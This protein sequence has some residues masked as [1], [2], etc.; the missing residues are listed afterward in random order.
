MIPASMNLRAALQ[1]C[2][3]IAVYWSPELTGQ[4]ANDPLPV[5]ADVAKFVGV[6]NGT[7]SQ[8]TR[9]ATP[10]TF[11]YPMILEIKAMQDREITALIDWPDSRS[12]HTRTSGAGIVTPDCVSWV[13]M[14]YMQ[15]TDADLFGRYMARIAKDGTLEGK[16]FDPE[17]L[18][19]FGSLHL[20]RVDLRALEAFNNAN[21]EAIDRL[22]S[23]SE[24]IESLPLR[25]RRLSYLT[26]AWLT[27]R[28]AFDFKAPDDGVTVYRTYA[29]RLA[30]ALERRESLFAQEHI[31]E[32][33][34]WLQRGTN[35]TIKAC[36]VSLP[37]E[38]SNTNKTYPARIEVFGRGPG[39][40]SLENVV[41]SSETPF[42]T[43]R[44]ITETGWGPEALNVLLSE[45]KALFSVDDQRIVV[46]F[47]REV[48]T[49]PKPVYADNGPAGAC[50]SLTKVSIPNTT[51][52][53][54]A[55]SNGVCMVTATVTH[56]PAR[57]AVKVLIA[58]P[59]AGWNG[60]FRG[61]GGGGFRAGN[62]F[63]MRRAATLGYAAGTTDIRP[64]AGGGSF[65]LDA[66]GRL[67]WQAVVNFAYLGV[68]DMTVVGK[69]LTEAF[70]GKPPR[71]SYFVGTSTGGRQG[72]MEAQRYPADYDGIVS[73]AP[74]LNIPQLTASYMWPQL[75]MLDA[76]N[77][78]SAAKLN[79]ATT[80][81]IAAC[82]EQDGLKD[83]V[84]DEPSRCTYDPKTLVGTKVD[85]GT[86]TES[87]AAVIRKIWEG[88][89][90]RAGN[91][92]WHGLARGA[93]LL[94]LAGTDGTPLTGRP[95]GLTRDWFRY[96]LL[97]DPQWDWTTITAA[98]FERRWK[99]GIE[100][101]GAVIGSDDPDLT[102]FR[103]R[104][105]KILA[106]HG[107]ADQFI[108]AEIT[109][110]YYKRVQQRIGGA[111][112]TAEF[113]RLF[114]V[115]GVDHGFRGP[116][117]SPTGEID[118][119]IG[120]VEEGKAPDMLIGERRES[121][122]KLLGT[123]PLFAYPRAAKYKGRGSPDN[124]A[125]FTSSVIGQ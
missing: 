21:R 90:D 9:S 72:L 80:A 82:D 110:D 67:N 45:I 87:D 57:D 102:R 13:E 24:Q 61:E 103:D 18:Q 89:R 116:G 69:A 95:N 105:G 2:A 123:R 100:Q 37:S 23:A 92:L 7:F 83:G 22:L 32:I 28:L 59:M 97:Q 125:S 63:R 101:Y 62:T 112:K 5:H 15:R 33:P 86:F 88:P 54:A 104:G 107:L 31:A 84:I 122:G 8:K 108:P 117:P 58:L 76:K 79:A 26:T 20:K 74:A 3:G 71:Y 41:E 65:A 44:P 81:A 14:S 53:S 94:T 99:Q 40:V 85:D 47:G 93:S 17:D 4:T 121:N 109:I 34:I 56:P 42:I 111:E 6:W 50:E 96:F 30:A 70:Y 115:P 77:F 43:L 16:Y 11:S 60:R 124:A 49:L 27:N 19:E 120:W 46:A 78:V 48:E 25:W 36:F 114:L 12:G 119:I 75:V 39:P 64:E 10:R 118:A 1:F 98:E 68:H 106:Y 91:L 52:N 35:R 66:N 51:I 113:F 38:F 29:Q 55:V 73:A